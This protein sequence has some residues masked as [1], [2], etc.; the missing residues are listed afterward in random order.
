MPPSTVM[1]YF[2]TIEDLLLTALTA[3]NDSCLRRLAEIDAHD[4]SRALRELAEE[5]VRGAEANRARAVAEYELFVLAAR[6]PAIRAE[7]NRWTQALDRFIARFVSDPIAR[8]GV[9]AA[10]DGLFI[11]VLNSDDPPRQE[12]I[13]AVL[14]QLTGQR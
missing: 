12:H 5:I 13:L 14:L 1:Y 9:T 4:D 6:H 3:C 11:R 7:A 2:P 8:D 10:V